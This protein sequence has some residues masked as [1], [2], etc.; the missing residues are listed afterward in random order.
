MYYQQK[1]DTFIR[2]F[3][4]IGYITSI[5]LFNDRCTNES[6]AVFL[7]ALKR[8]PQSLNQLVDIIMTKFVGVERQTILHDAEEF[9]D[10]LLPSAAENFL[11]LGRRLQ[12]CF[13]NAAKVCL[14]T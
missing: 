10:E 8:T 14:F 13:I 7:Q 9:Y 12:T 1:R 11:V 4:G 2:N 5:G 3:D 6:G